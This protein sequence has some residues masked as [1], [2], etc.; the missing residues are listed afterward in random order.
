M[1]PFLRLAGGVL[2]E[3]TVEE[4]VPAVKKNMQQLR[5]VWDLL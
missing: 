2:V 5:E 4:V 1:F 3:R